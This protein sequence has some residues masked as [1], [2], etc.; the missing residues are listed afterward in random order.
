MLTKPCP[1]AAGIILMCRIP[2]ECVSVMLS[3]TGGRCMHIRDDVLCFTFSDN[4]IQ[5]FSALRWKTVCVMIS[6][7]LTGPA[8]CL[9]M[10]LA[11]FWNKSLKLKLQWSLYGNLCYSFNSGESQ[12]SILL[13]DLAVLLWLWFLLV[14]VADPPFCSKKCCLGFFM[15]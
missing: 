2:S 3:D 15:L 7:W 12:G 1:C 6:F 14:Q 13:T 9:R 11:N 5:L 10:P 4:C 8:D